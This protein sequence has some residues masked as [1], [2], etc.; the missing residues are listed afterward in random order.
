MIKLIATDIDGTIIPECEK[1]IPEI[2]FDEVEKLIDSGIVFCFA[3]GRQYE[4]LKKLCK[5]LLEKAYFM[6]E[7]G[8]VIF[9]KGEAPAL[10][11][12]SSID[13]EK[14][15][16]ICHAVMDDPDSEVFISGE[17]TTYIC[18]KKMKMEDIEPHVLCNH[19]EIVPSPESIS[20]DIVKVSAFCK[21]ADTVFRRLAPEWE[22]TFSVSIAGGHWVDFTIANKGTGIR[23]L[24]SYLGIELNETAAFG[25]NYN[26]LPMLE[27]VGNPYIMENAAAD[28]KI[29]IPNHCRNVAEE[30]RKIRLRQAEPFN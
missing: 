23:A 4:N 20:E 10:I 9:S 30:M 1:F 2:I 22:N 27:I 24:C 17:N 6:C 13:R 28:L 14:A 12:K 18:P 26:D 19:I 11:S 5:P 16:I 7:N 25:D 8:A 21:D 3:S 15:M 29:K